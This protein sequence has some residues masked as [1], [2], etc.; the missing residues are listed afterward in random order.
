MIEAH[1][2]P[3]SRRRFLQQALGLVVAASAGL[4]GGGVW[5]LLRLGRRGVAA[6][7]ANRATDEGPRA[8]L[9][10]RLQPGDDLA[11]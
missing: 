10:A 2:P 6:W 4:V 7:R 3:P 9:P 11:G 5:G 1:H 8:A